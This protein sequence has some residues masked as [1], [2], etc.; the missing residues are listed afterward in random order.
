MTAE[1]ITS[2]SLRTIFIT[3]LLLTGR[4]RLAEATIVR[5]FDRLDDPGS[6]S[7]DELLRTTVLASACFPDWRNVPEREDLSFLP[8]ELRHILRLPSDLRKCFVLRVLRAVPC[9]SC[10]RLLGLDVGTVDRNTGLAAKALAAISSKREKKAKR[11]DFSR[12]H[13]IARRA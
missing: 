4:V 7:D 11:H 13:F 2:E 10:A 8:P 9:E 12:I 1:M 3:A 6:A 5:G